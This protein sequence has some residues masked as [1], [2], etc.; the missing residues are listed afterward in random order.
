MV[1]VNLDWIRISYA[2]FHNILSKY[3][4]GPVPVD[5]EGDPIN[6]EEEEEYNL[7]NHDENFRRRGLQRRKEIKI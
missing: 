4:N 2:V 3:L 6:D 1:R 5:E 7:E